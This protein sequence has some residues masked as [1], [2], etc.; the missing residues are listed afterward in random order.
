MRD[1]QPLNLNV[2]TSKRN[3]QYII[4]GHFIYFSQYNGG[5]RLKIYILEGAHYE[6]RFEKQC[7]SRSQSE[8][9][10]VPSSLF[11]T[12]GSDWIGARHKGISNGQLTNNQTSSLEKSV[13]MPNLFHIHGKPPNFCYS[14]PCNIGC[15]KTKR[16]NKKVSFEQH[17]RPCPPTDPTVLKW[18]IKFWDGK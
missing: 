9:Q 11:I 3:A 5:T 12:P 13:L 18:V 15:F 17:Q 2:Y 7:S 16:T 8:Y 14:P 1:L 10:G 4:Y 6:K